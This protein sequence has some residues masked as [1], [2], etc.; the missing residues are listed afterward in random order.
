MADR[1]LKH[2]EIK[3]LSKKH[4]VIVICDDIISPEN[5]GLIFRLCEAMSLEKLVLG[6]KTPLPVSE[7]VVRTARSTIK[8]VNYIHV[9]SIPSFL[10]E[11]KTGGYKIIG[12]E[13]TDKS[14][15]LRDYA[16]NHWEKIALVIGSENHGVSEEVL[17][18]IEQNVHVVMYGINTSIN[19]VQALS[20]ALYEIT[21]Q[22]N[23]D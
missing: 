17:E 4:R 22:F 11:L 12:L 23:I 16:F 10:K 18:V 21:S 15:P 3:N 19:V 13:I 5:V 6:G 8:Y 14:V 9:D 2:S 20:I 1:Q 7:K